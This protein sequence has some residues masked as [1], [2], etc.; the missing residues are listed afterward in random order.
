MDAALILA[1]YILLLACAG[2]LADNYRLSK[3]AK[4]LDAAGA[5]LMQEY[6]R[7]RNL[8]LLIELSEPGSA[9]HTHAVTSARAMLRP[10]ISDESLDEIMHQEILDE[11]AGT[12]G[13]LDLDT[14]I[15]TWSGSGT[16]PESGSLARHHEREWS[17]PDQVYDQ[18]KQ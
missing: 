9:Q 11:I 4:R 8:H 2:L 12:Q 5:E 6:Q 13:E 16:W 3:K 10:G 1:V 7:L 18:D 17:K 15:R 14:G